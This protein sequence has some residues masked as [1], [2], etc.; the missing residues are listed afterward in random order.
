MVIIAE[1][2]AVD[3][4]TSRPGY[5]VQAVDLDTDAGAVLF[6]PLPLPPGADMPLRAGTVVAL[7]WAMEVRAEGVEIVVTGVGP[8]DLT[9]ER[10]V[11]DLHRYPAALAA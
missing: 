10:V 5:T 3:L 7:E 8:V 1:I 6:L 4:H 2:V 11:I 9:P